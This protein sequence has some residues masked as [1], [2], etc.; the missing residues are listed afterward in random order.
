MMVTMFSNTVLQL[1]QLPAGGFEQYLRQ[2]VMAFLWQRPASTRGPIPQSEVAAR[3]RASDSTELRMLPEGQGTVRGTLKQTRQLGDGTEES[4]SLI[5]DEKM[6]YNR[7]P[8]GGIVHPT[9]TLKGCLPKGSQL[10]V[11][12][13]KNIA[14]SHGILFLFQLLYTSQE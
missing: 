4:C 9:V 5:P 12:F 2:L 13:L 3:S 11:A 7:C 14:W 8:K 1:W 6:A 10:P